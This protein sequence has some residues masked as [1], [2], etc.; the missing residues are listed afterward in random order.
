MHCPECDS[1]ETTVKDSR[2]RDG[3]PRRR[4]WCEGCGF[5]FKTVEVPA[6]GFQKELTIPVV[7]ETRL[8]KGKLNMRV[9]I[10]TRR[11]TLSGGRARGPERKTSTDY[12][13]GWFALCLFFEGVRWR[14]ERQEKVAG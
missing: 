5:R 3:L 4:R 12:R 11:T 14:S 8:Y 1:P 6:D 7:A 9:R 2:V 10:D 13:V